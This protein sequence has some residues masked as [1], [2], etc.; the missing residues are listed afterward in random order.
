[1]TRQDTVSGFG[2]GIGSS[3]S[4]DPASLDALQRLLHRRKLAARVF[5]LLTGFCLLLGIP[6]A[7][8]DRRGFAALPA[9]LWVYVLFLLV[10]CGLLAGWRGRLLHAWRSGAVN[11]TGF[12][13][14]VASLS[15]LPRATLA[16]LLRSLPI[17]T[18]EQDRDLSPAGRAALAAFSDWRWAEETAAALLP[19]LLLT[20]PSGAATLLLLGWAAPDL[21]GGIVLLSLAAS[22]LLIR[23]GI[24]RWRRR[25]LEAAL[26]AL[27]AET[28]RALPGLVASLDWTVTSEARR[29]AMLRTV[30][31]R[32]PR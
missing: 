5:V 7:F 20:L 30:E 25:Q 26:A 4:K 27:D 24:P 32:I 16:A 6:M 9:L 28:A 12:A 18:P 1:M 8:F 15:T 17:L 19:G 21:P 11:L 13:V 29:R 3:A 23:F 31:Q 22:L 14:A 2:Q 10:D